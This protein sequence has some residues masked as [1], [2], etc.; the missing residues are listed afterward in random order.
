M[1]ATVSK[2]GPMIA[3]GSAKAQASKPK[4]INGSDPPRATRA[5]DEATKRMVN[6]LAQPVHHQ[7]DMASSSFVLESR[8]GGF[9]HAPLWAS[10]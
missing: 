6:I 3:V 1:E 7:G 4:P 5:R 10:I 9:L 8:L 2:M